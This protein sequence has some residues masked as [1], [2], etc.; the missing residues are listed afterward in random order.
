[1]RPKNYHLLIAMVITSFTGALY[2]FIPA[3]P[4]IQKLIFLSCV[5]LL[6]SR[7]EFMLRLSQGEKFYLVLLTSFAIFT[8]FSSLFLWG[9]LPSAALVF[10]KYLFL[11]FFFVGAHYFV[12][13]CLTSSQKKMASLVTFII[14]IQ[15][16]FVMAKVSILGRIDEGFLIGSMHNDAGQLGFLFP[17]IFIPII[18]YLL[19]DRRPIICLITVL[20][21]LTFGVL[22]EKRSIVYIGGIIALIS[23]WVFSKSKAVKSRKSRFSFKMAASVAVLL[24]I[25]VGAK[26]IGSLSGA[27]SVGSIDADN[28][29]EYLMAYAIEYLTMDYGGSLQG[30]ENLASVDQNVQVG[31]L[32]VAAFSAELIA[33]RDLSNMIFG[34]GAG[35]VTP[36]S[37]LG[38]T[39][40]LFDRYGFRGAIS[41][42]LELALEMGVVGLLFLTVLIGRPIRQLCRSWRDIS[43]S[44][45]ENLRRTWWLLFIV[46]CVFLFDILFYS[47]ILFS[48]LPLPFLFFCTLIGVNELSVRCRHYRKFR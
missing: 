3:G 2:Q 36:S 46:F 47:N 38:A 18:C 5:L 32:I 31:R 15:I 26:S 34:D 29:V 35:Y 43:A 12:G 8:I 7:H 4:V 45:D 27:E 10:Q 14:G 42:T 1:M 25:S 30:D 44:G 22:N 13:F 17:A 24:V 16:V 21:L 9:S 6:L 28:R 37:R 19:L 48:T 23:L 41:T 40:I 11:T 39:D 33:N 20:A